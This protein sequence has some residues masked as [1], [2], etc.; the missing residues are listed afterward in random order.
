MDPGRVQDVH[1]YS[2]LTPAGRS[3]P[4]RWAAYNPSANMVVVR[5]RRRLN[6]H[7]TFDVK[8]SAVGSGGIADARGVRLDGAGGGAAGSD[9]VT[10]LSRKNV[11]LTYGEIVRQ[12]PRWLFERFGPPPGV[13]LPKPM[14]RSH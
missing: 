8:V 1:N 2:I 14:T 12:L 6:L 7:Q 9:F 4:I 13:T 3:I 11:V 5:P 10:T